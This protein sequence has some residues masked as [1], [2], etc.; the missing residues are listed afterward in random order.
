ME[1]VILLL[2]RRP[3]AKLPHQL[4]EHLAKRVLCHGFPVVTKNILVAPE[5]RREMGSRAGELGLFLD[6]LGFQVQLLAGRLP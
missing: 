6:R 2:R 5:D 3:R 4:L 1:D